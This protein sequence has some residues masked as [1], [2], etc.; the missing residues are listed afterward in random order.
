MCWPAFITNNEGGDNHVQRQ[1]FKFRG[2]VLVFGVLRSVMRARL[3]IFRLISMGQSSFCGSFV[4]RFIPPM[5]F[6]ITASGSDG[7]CLARGSYCPRPQAGENT[8]HGRCHVLCLGHDCCI[9]V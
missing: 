6:E 3:V 5:Y 4:I 8:L 7:S 9:R 2:A 1:T